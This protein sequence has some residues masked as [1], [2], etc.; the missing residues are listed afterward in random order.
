[1]SSTITLLTFYVL[2]LVTVVLQLMMIVDRAR[3]VRKLKGE[4]AV[5]LNLKGS[6]V[7]K[8]KTIIQ[9]LF[10]VKLEMATDEKLNQLRKSAIKSSMYWIISALITLTLPLLL[11]KLLE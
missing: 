6:A 11:Y 4:K 5:I 7:K 1:M 3:F 9:V 2:A 10:P 8:F